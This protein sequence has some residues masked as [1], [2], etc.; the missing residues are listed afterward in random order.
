[1]IMLRIREIERVMVNV[2]L[3][4]LLFL[5]C[6][7]FLIWVVCKFLCGVVVGCGKNLLY[8]LLDLE[9]RFSIVFI[10]CLISL[11]YLM[12]YVRYFNSVWN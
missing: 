2:V 10:F 5:V 8:I 6:G 12:F 9:F 7:D 1:M 3:C 4:F 11:V